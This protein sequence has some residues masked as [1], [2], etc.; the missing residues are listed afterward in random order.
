M[1]IVTNGEFGYELIVVVPYAYHLHLQ[2][3]LNST[4]SCLDTKP[5]YYFSNNHT[6]KFDKR[7]PCLG[8]IY[9][10]QGASFNA[11]H[12]SNPDFSKWTFPNYKEIYKNTE[13]SFNKPLLMISNKKYVRG[14]TQRHGFFNDEELAYLFNEYQNE[15]QIIYNRAK[16]DNIIVDTQIPNDDDTDF[17]LIKKYNVIDINE[18]YNQYKNKY[19]FNTL[20]LM[21]SANCDKFISVQGGSSILSSAFGGKN[22]IYAF[23]GEELKVGSFKNWYNRFSN[24][25]ID[26]ASDF[27]SFKEKLKTF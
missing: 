12:T 8:S 26:Y 5:F 23:S 1:N 25:N 21:L 17:D 16:S 22:L 24:C 2:G 3:K 18:L 14:S 27:N 9:N 20:Q 15:Y 13:F 6:E 4:T 7:T 19:T 11:L 10:I